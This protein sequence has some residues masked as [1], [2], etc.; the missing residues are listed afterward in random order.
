M[1]VLN[2]LTDPRLGGPQIRSLAIAKHLRF[3]GIETVFLLPSGEDKFEQMASD[4]GFAV[5]R[6]GLSRIKPPHEIINNLSY[7]TRFPSAVQRIRRV[8]VKEDIDIVH[9]NMPVNYQTAVA[10]AF[11]DAQ[12][13]WH[14]NDTSTP[15]FLIR[16]SARMA[17]I[18]ADKIVVAANAVDRY[19]FENVSVDTTLL[20]APVDVNEFDPATVQTGCKY[21]EE[22][23][24]INI[25]GA[26][27]GTVGN[28]NPIKG[29][30]NLLKAVSQLKDEHNPVT[31]LVVGDLLDTRD[32]YVNRL[33]ELRRKFDLE[34]TVHFLGRRSDIPELLSTFDLFVLSSVAEACPMAVLEAMAMKLPVVATE[35]GGVPEQIADGEHGWLVP[36]E[37]PAQLAEAIETA[38]SSPEECERRGVQARQRAIEVFSLARCANRHEEVYKSTLE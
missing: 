35:V 19:Y 28:I 25:D 14:F 27:I 12:L 8:I 16:F 1:R 11:S 33:Y 37:K 17:E 9:A 15:N 20:Y 30:D 21:L 26:V 7:V 3:K 18:L 22:E 36:P 23:L 4:A 31:T 5:R 34:D 24:N 2:S 29:H 38:L 32:E 13:V 6:P 10:T